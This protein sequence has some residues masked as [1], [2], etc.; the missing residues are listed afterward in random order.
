MNLTVTDFLVISVLASWAV[1]I[2]HTRCLLWNGCLK[3]DKTQN[4]TQ[5]AALVAWLLLQ[6]HIVAKKTRYRVDKVKSREAKES[7]HHPSEI[8]HTSLKSDYVSVANEHNARRIQTHTCSCSSSS[9]SS[10]M[11]SSSGGGSLSSL[12]AITTRRLCPSEAMDTTQ[13]LSCGI[14]F[15]R[16]SCSD[17]SY[18]IALV[19]S[20]RISILPHAGENHQSNHLTKKSA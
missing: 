14:K 3:S 6:G 13:A 20:T 7:K 8:M 19:D 11:S 15:R 2:H 5:S 12:P 9:S 10:E 4:F 16:R 18:S 17:V 1:G